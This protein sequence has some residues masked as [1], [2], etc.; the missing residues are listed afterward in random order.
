LR[1]KAKGVVTFDFVLRYASAP[2]WPGPI[3][4]TVKFLHITRLD[5]NGFPNGPQW[6]R[7]LHSLTD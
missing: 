4:G 1:T 3:H 6:S 5:R 2:S 7:Y